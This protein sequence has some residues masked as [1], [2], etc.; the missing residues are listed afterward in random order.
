MEALE[1]KRDEMFDKLQNENNV[2]IANRLDAEHATLCQEI[3]LE[4]RVLEKLNETF[5]I[6]E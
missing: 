5:T 3:E 1:K 6:T 4:T 2:T